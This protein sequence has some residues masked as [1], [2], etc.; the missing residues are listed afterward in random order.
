MSEENHKIDDLLRRDVH[1]QLEAFDWDR[2]NAHLSDR[3]ERI[4]RPRLSPRRQ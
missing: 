4:E 2:F 3:L 1:R